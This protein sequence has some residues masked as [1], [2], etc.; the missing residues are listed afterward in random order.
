MRRLALV[1]VGLAAWFGTAA[2][3]AS[4]TFHLNMV[5]EVMLASSSGDPSVRFVELLD[6]GGAEEAF[7]PAFAPFKLTVYDAAG[8]KL[9]EQTLDPNG[10]RAAAMADREYLVSTGA[11]DSA[12]GV[13]GDEKLTISLP[14]A[15]GQ[16]CFEGNPGAVSCMTWG[17]ITKP[18]PTSSQGT[19]AVHGPVPANGQS[20]QRLTDNSVVA[21]PPTPKAHN[22]A[23]AGGGGGGMTAF[24]GVSFPKS[25]AKVDSHGRAHVAVR[26][27]AGSGGCS[28]KL[29]L[30]ARAAPH[31]RLGSASFSIAA[32]ATKQVSVKLSA[33]ARKQLKA[34][35]KLKAT[36][37]A[38]AT[39]AAG[40]RKRT[41]TGIVLK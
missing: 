34:H 9:G 20:D 4:A 15:A 22:K 25:S 2:E 29:V 8:N 36:A 12:F 1:A 27:P 23:A 30:S 10:L 26:C 39:D 7:P 38:T 13:T 16:V 40:A 3:P 28:G 32:G 41:S 31:K 35:G 21:A 5:N 17:T 24:A 6:H 37:A 11:T 33:A 19:G 14:A 18:V